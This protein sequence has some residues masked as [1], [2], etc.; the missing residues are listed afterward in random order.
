MIIIVILILIVLVLELLRM[1]SLF[2]KKKY[3][4]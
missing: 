1:F 4:N 2:Y 3:N